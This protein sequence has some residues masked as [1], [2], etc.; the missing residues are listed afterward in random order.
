MIKQIAEKL[1][2]N[3]QRIA[4]GLGI[5]LVFLCHSTGIIQIPLLNTLDNYIYDA[6]LR[7]T[8][9]G[10]IDERIVILDID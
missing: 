10:G 8:M 4:I 6:R 7:M 3:V 5:A 1:K 9:P 2:Q